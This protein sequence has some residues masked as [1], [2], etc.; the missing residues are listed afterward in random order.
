MNHTTNSTIQT[1]L[2]DQLKDAGNKLLNPPFSIDELL[3]LL[4][5]VENLLANVQQA[6][7]KSMRRALFPSVKAL[8]ADQLFRHAN[9][10]VKVAVASCISEITR[11]SAPD[12]PYA[13]DQMKEAFK[14]IVSLLDNL[15]DKS[16]WS[17][18]KMTSILET[19][20]KVRSCVVM[21][22]LECDT[23]ILEMF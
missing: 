4:D 3:T 7:S 15:S 8:V 10:D 9:V 22:D 23:L 1:A 21:L 17:Y 14:L 19:V 5:R 18:R 13:D 20:A 16:S 11:I 12:A 2:E 6:P